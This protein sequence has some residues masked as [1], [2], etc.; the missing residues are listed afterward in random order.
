MKMNEEEKKLIPEVY[1]KKYE[2]TFGEYL[3]KNMM[4]TS[5]FRECCKIFIQIAEG[6]HYLQKIKIIHSDLKPA[7]I[8]L[9]KSIEGG[10]NGN[11][12]IIDFGSAI[13]LSDENF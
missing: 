1:V 8:M 2:E 12:K 13:K 3:K 10:G 7:N 11:V 4:T 9:E 5:T 6:I